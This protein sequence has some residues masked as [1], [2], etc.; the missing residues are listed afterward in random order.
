M[1]PE[2]E[3]RPSKQSIDSVL[4][5]VG[6]QLVEL[7][8][9]KPRM[10]VRRLNR[11]EYDNTIRD[12]FGVDVKPARVFPEDDSA[13]GFD[14]V[15]SA[16]TVSPLLLEKYLNAAQFITART[17]YL[18]RPDTVKHHWKGAELPGVNEKHLN[19]AGRMLPDGKG[20]FFQ[21]GPRP[22]NIQNT[23]AVKEI[24]ITAGTK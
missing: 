16:L 2:E 3:P 12:L 24:I 21:L 5:W 10:T 20:I 23:N 19:A 11:A 9:G 14:N 13:H 17:I 7:E 1:P 22:N 4:K 8:K 18:E 6:E 15:G